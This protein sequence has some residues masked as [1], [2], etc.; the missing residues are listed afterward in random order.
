MGDLGNLIAEKDGTA[1]YEKL[2][3]CACINWEDGR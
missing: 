3:I 1:V 2:S